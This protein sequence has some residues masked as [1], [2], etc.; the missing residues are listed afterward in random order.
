MSRSAQAG[1][2]RTV[3]WMDNCIAGMTVNERLAHF[4]LFEAFD[5]AISSR[6]FF[7]VASV[8]QQAKFTD[9]QAFETATAVLAKSGSK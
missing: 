6:D 1:Q 8:L 3:I 7:A 5:A 9:E 4:G 2:H